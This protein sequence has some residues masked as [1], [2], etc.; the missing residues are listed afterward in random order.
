[1]QHYHS[2][3]LN[4]LTLLFINA[5]VLLLLLVAEDDLSLYHQNLSIRQ[6]YA[7]QQAQLYQQYQ[8]Q[9]SVF[10]QSNH[11]DSLNYTERLTA[12]KYKFGSGINHFIDCE[13]QQIFVQEPKKNLNSPLKKYFNINY[14]FSTSSMEPTSAVQPQIW[15]VEQNV[16][17]LE[18]DFYGV[19]VALN[20]VEILGKGTIFGA[21]IYERELRYGENIKIVFD[22][23]I[24]RKL[25][26][27]YSSWKM[28]GGWRDFDAI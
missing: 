5:I 21:I 17:T 12:E 15:K 7:L 25:S 14:P 3:Y 2:G 20:D 23:E 10:C 22:A 28:R 1:M 8:Q 11:I 18:Q 13:L 4:L 9:Y 24:I 16:I 27:R 19:I 26:K 6:D